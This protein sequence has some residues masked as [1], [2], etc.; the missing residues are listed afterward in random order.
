MISRRSLLAAL[1]C[2]PLLAPGPTTLAGGDRHDKKARKARE[3]EE[4]RQALQRGEI[5]PLARILAIAG[6]HADG[7]VIEIELERKHA[8][9]IYEVKVLTRD[10]DVRKLKLD[11]RDGRLVDDGKD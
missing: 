5:L 1:V 6:T 3:R 9:Y 7:D 4:V 2:V 10:G 8:R 11:A